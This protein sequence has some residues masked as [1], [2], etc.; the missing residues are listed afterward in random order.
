MKKTTKIIV[1]TICAAALLAIGC[2]E[3]VSATT[4]LNSAPNWTGAAAHTFSGS[5][6]VVGL[7]GQDVYW[8]DNG[9]PTFW[10]DP[11]I[12][13]FGGAYVLTSI[14]QTHTLGFHEHTF[15]HGNLVGES[16]NLSLLHTQQG[17]PSSMEFVDP[18]VS[19]FSKYWTS[20]Q[21]TEICDLAAA[22]HGNFG[23][24]S[25]SSSHLYMSFRACELNDSSSCTAGVM[26]LAFD[27]D[28]S[29]WSPKQIGS[30]Q[31]IWI[32][33]PNGTLF[34]SECMPIAVT[35]RGDQSTQYLVVADPSMDEVS[36]YEAYSLASGPVSDLQT[37]SGAYI[38]DIA[39]EGRADGN[40]D[41]AFL[42]TLWSD[43]R[44]EHRLLT[45]GDIASGTPFLTEYLPT[46]IQ[47][48]ATRNIG[49]QSSSG[50]LFTFGDQV[51]R[52]S[53]EQ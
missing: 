39:L 52:R 16:D 25:Q 18:S 47:D 44:V 51:V 15:V 50:Q 21:V 33:K 11:L 12:D 22:S 41:Y 6:G 38:E 10:N 17:S 42:V 32:T 8:F 36:A 23:N 31:Q 40:I 14:A 5:H 27:T 43:G 1:P 34:S 45:D 28:I 26:E 9:G 3:F 48:I 4:V 30:T 46:H 7:A 29:W 20:Y 53:Y 19:T 13:E 24:P 37:F 2:Y 49:A 35:S